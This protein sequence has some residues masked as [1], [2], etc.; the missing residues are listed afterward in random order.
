MKK[1]HICLVSLSIAL[2]RERTGFE[3]I[4]NYLKKNGHNV[5]LI[6]GKWNYELND[7]DI[8]QLNLIRKR[9]F[10]V[11][12]FNLKV[13][14]YLKNHNFDIVHGNGTKGTLPIILSNQK[15]FIT[16]LHDLGPF[17]SKFTT[18][19]ME[20]HL[21][22]YI[23]QKATYITTVSKFSKRGIKYFIPKIDANKIHILYNGIDAKYRPCPED[24]QKLKECLNIKGTVLLYLGRITNYKGVE[25]LITAYKIVKGKKLN[26]NLVIGGVPDYNMAKIYKIWR[27]ECQKSSKYRIFSNKLSLYFSCK[28]SG[29]HVKAN[30]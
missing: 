24:A 16:T 21:I 11:P 13:A 6:T 2:D 9:F 4:Y 12:Q 7:P 19:P 3:G 29:I 20:K 14:H 27:N 30:A 8:I 15:R 25:D 22:K 23:A 18:I 1:L 5:K 17:E 10:W 28:L 26:L